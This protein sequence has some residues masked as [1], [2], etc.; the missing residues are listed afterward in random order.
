[1][2]LIGDPRFATRKQRTD[3]HDEIVKLLRASSF[4]KKPRDYW[5]RALG[6]E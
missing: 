6:R 5:L 3:R 4:A 2:S 1:M